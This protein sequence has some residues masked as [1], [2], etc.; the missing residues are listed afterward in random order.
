MRIPLTSLLRSRSTP[1]ASSAVGR[2]LCW[3]DARVLP[4]T[5][6]SRPALL[7]IATGAYTAA[8]LRPRVRMFA[9]IHRTD[10]VHFEPVGPCRVLKRPLPPRVADALVRATVVT[11]LAFTAGL[12]HRVVGPLH[13]GLLLWTLSYRNSWSMVFHNDNNLVLH[14]AVLGLTRSADA[15]AP[16]A[17]ARRLGAERGHWCYAATHRGMQ[18]GTLVAYWL[19]GVA[20]VASTQ[21]WSWARGEGMRRQVAADALRKE[22]LG[23]RAGGLGLRIYPC[24]RLW[25]ILATGSLLLEIG[26]PLVFLHDRAGRVWAVCA[27]A[28]HVGIC[29]VMNITFRHNLS[30]VMYLPWFPV[31]RLLALGR[32]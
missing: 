27:W 17:A 16:G 26:A 3:L 10:P 24:T 5:P 13:A 12:C 7:R 4:T 14:T 9:R 19:A 20:K 25:T 29:W 21:G 31:E 1:G 28:M 11:D 22:L 15:L 8:Y 18:A 23:S 6:A 30:G 32:P 2:V